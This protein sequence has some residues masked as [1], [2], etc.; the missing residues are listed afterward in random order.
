MK[1]DDL[2]TAEQAEAAFYQ[3]F[4]SADLSAMMQVWSDEDEI[5]C[6]HPHGPR[7][8]GYDDIRESWSQILSNTPTIQF[9]LTELRCFEDGTIAIHYLNENIFLASDRQRQFSVLATNV[10]RRTSKGWRIILHHASPTPESRQRAEKEQ[11]E[12]A[13]VTVH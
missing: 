5:V 4:E 2:E 9:Q 3:A 8:V 10:Y 11:R 13:D 12:A 7:L 6:I 1:T